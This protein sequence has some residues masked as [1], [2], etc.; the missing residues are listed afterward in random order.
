[1]LQSTSDTHPPI[2]SQTHI[3]TQP[4]D[5]ISP[6]QTRK[7]HQAMDNHYSKST[8]S[9]KAWQSRR[10][11]NSKLK[12]QLSRLASITKSTATWLT[13]DDTQSITTNHYNKKT[14]DAIKSSTQT[15]LLNNPNFLSTYTYCNEYNNEH[16][17][18]RNLFSSKF[19]PSHVTLQY[20]DHYHWTKP[21]QQ[22]VILM[23]KSATYKSYQVVISTTTLCNH[24]WL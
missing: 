10:Y 6:T 11:Y 22:I 21:G 19:A 12:E 5:A 1:M 20:R 8:T 2:T 23:F 15:Q 14:S 24:G 3:T 9:T 17:T 18:T 4:H 7:D 16:Q 13:V